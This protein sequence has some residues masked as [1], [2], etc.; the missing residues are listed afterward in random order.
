MDL[1]VRHKMRDQRPPRANPV[2]QTDSAASYYN[3]SAYQPQYTEIDD[4][5]GAYEMAPKGNAPTEARI[6]VHV[7]N[8]PEKGYT[9]LGAIERAK[10]ETNSKKSCCL[11]SMRIA[12]ATVLIANV[13]VLVLLI[14]GS[15]VD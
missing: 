4:I 6:E 11:I 14:F 13:A 1:P 10:Q 8:Q 5:N 3:A 7:Q 9:G 12:F 15:K 2:L